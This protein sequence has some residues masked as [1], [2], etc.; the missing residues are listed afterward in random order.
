MASTGG[1][2][3]EVELVPREIR[4]Q[5]QRILESPEFQAPERGRRFLRHVVEEALE[6]RS[7][8][9]NAYVIAQTVFGRDASFD[10]QNDPVVRIEAGRIRRALERYY[11]VSG[12]RDPVLITIPKG[13]YAPSF[14]SLRQ[15]IGPMPETAGGA[16]AAGD[17]KSPSQQP[18][19][20]TYR[21]LILPIGVPAVFA[22]VTLLALI[23]PLESYLAPPA[24]PGVA[25]AVD[26]DIKIAFEPLSVL[27]G[28]KGGVEMAQGLSDQLITKL[29]KLG[30]IVVVT[31]IR[32]VGAPALDPTL[33][34]QGSLTVEDENIHVHIR[35]VRSV[36]GTVVWTK[37]V[38]RAMQDRNLLDIED[39]IAGEIASEISKA[40]KPK[41]MID[42]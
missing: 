12:R 35:L 18:R 5:L 9:L 36:D 30:G 41:G 24:S 16:D 38:D 6:G 42:P 37:Q 21:D 31:P 26:P 1:E 2:N 39:E 13:H 7:A 4:A 22:V 33:Y 11:L 29:T 15:F 17:M 32:S 20:T 23:R 14:E 8:Q 3:H 19:P 40:R 34:L 27:G 25:A 28:I 10:A